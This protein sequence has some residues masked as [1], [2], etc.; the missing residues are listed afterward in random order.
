MV[1][2]SKFQNYGLCTF[3][4]IINKEDSKIKVKWSRYRPG[5]AQRVGRSI[6][7]LFHDRDTRRVWVVSSM[8][9]LDF[10]P[11]KDQVPI[12][13]RLGGP[14]GQSGRAE[15]LIP[16][17]ISSR[18][19]QPIGSN[20]EDSLQ[21]NAKQDLGHIF[22]SHSKRTGQNHYCHIKSLEDVAKFKYSRIMVINQTVF[23]K[24]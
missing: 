5:V 4:L 22:M 24:V 18:T 3:L 13:Q 9:R 12:L 7:L 16:T 1:L 6:A 10:T 19:V 20:K 23:D 17:R 15:N 11:E 21:V 14:Q 2:K 8:L